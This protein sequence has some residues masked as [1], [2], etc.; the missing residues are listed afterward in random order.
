MTLTTILVLSVLLALLI[1]LLVFV[2]QLAEAIGRF[3]TS[4]S[5]AY[6]RGKKSLENMENGFARN[7]PRKKKRLILI[8]L[9][10][11]ELTVVLLSA[12]FSPDKTEWAY[13]ILSGTPVGGVVNT[14]FNPNGFSLELNLWSWML[15][16]M[17]FLLVT[18]TAMATEKAMNSKPLAFV[19]SLVFT[20]FTS[21]L[22]RLFV[23]YA[24][25][26]LFAYSVEGMDQLYPALR[27]F[28]VLGLLL[29][30]LCA[31]IGL[32]STLRAFFEHAKKLLL[33]LVAA[34]VFVGLLLALK[35]TLDVGRAQ[36]T[37]AFTSMLE[38]LKRQAY[39]LP[40][41]KS[42]K[43]QMIVTGT[44]TVLYDLGVV[45]LKNTKD[46]A[47]KA[48]RRAKE[49]EILEAAKAAKIYLAEGPESLERFLKDNPD[50]CEKYRKLRK[51]KKDW[52]LDFEARLILLEREMEE[53]EERRPEEGAEA[54]AIKRNAATPEGAAWLRKMIASD[55][56]DNHISRRQKKLVSMDPKEIRKKYIPD[57][58]TLDSLDREFRTS[59]FA[60]IRLNHR[61][62]RN[63]YTLFSLSIGILF[64]VLVFLALRLTWWL[65]KSAFR[66]TAG[67]AAAV[68]LVGAFYLVFTLVAALFCRKVKVRDTFLSMVLLLPAVWFA[69]MLSATATDWVR[70]GGILPSL[71]ASIFCGVLIGKL[72]GI[73]YLRRIFSNMDFARFC[74][75]RQ[76]YV[77]GVNRISDKYVSTTK[78]IKS[79]MIRKKKFDLM[80]AC[81]ARYDEL[82]AYLT[83][84]ERGGY[85]A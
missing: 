27:I 22:N 83:A 69:Y 14:F 17:S 15:S 85:P 38:F 57:V 42:F 71:A 34:A 7:T 53:A 29:L 70:G 13:S 58:G 65:N 3:F 51:K 30:F 67:A 78:E 28:P 49:E 59:R 62:A 36:H 50:V 74:S 9:L 47:K 77:D 61:V 5:R 4:V 19:H 35:L 84:S 73:I 46:T 64:Q 66:F 79:M 56:R 55:V 72:T 63:G 24:V 45:F 25:G 52:Q 60:F 33:S 1:L 16:G 41:D 68:A 8:L 82:R 21:T 75:L 26:N 6:D 12:I 81:E 39:E 54:A 80:I 11:F 23:K 48:V 32:V 18:F 40:N 37:A 76:L 10:V 31:A 20:Y 2:P 44:M 43:A